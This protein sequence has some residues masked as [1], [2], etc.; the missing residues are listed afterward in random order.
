[1]INSVQI[2]YTSLLK[3]DMRKYPLI[4]HCEICNS[5]FTVN[6]GAEF[7][8]TTCSKVCGNKKAVKNRSGNNHWNFGNPRNIKSFLGKSHSKE[9][10]EKIRK[11]K[12]GT[13]AWNKGLKNVFSKEAIKKMSL[14]HKGKHFSSN[15]EFKKGQTP[16][17]KGLK[18]PQ[19]SGKNNSS[20]KGGITPERNKIR[21]SV[22]YKLWVDSVYAKDNFTCIKCGENRIR[23]LTAHHIK[24]FAQYEELRLAIDNGV[25]FCRDCH[26]QFH[27]IYKKKDNNLK[28]VQEFLNNHFGTD[29]V[30]EFII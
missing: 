14:A 29:F 16:W 30:H 5:E 23:K 22:E 27:K 24:N 1:M 19:L 2:S 12:I 17:N 6:N 3:K 4:K 9:T 18:L 13:P 11:A 21:S 25:T 10:K 20:W 8:N 7:R 28:Q 26:K 15:T